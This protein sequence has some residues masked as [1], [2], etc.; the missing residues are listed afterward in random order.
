MAE[1]A[2]RSSKL[3][4]AA[5]KRCIAVVGGAVGRLSQAL[6]GEHQDIHWAKNT[7]KAHLRW[8][9]AKAFLNADRPLDVTI[10]VLPSPRLIHPNVMERSRIA[11]PRPPAR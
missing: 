2:F 5:V 11:A 7:D 10:R 1:A 4:Q 9:Y 3:Y 8:D 6:R